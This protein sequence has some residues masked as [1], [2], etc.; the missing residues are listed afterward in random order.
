MLPRRTL[1]RSGLALGALSGLAGCGVAARA[2]REG[3][4][5]MA[6]PGP[7]DLDWAKTAWQ[8]F[9]TARNSATGLVEA[10]AGAGFAMTSTVGD[11]I[12]AAVCAYRLGAIDQREFD[13]T[14]SQLLQF[15]AGMALSGGE[16]PARFYDTSSGQ[17]IDPPEEGRDPGWSAVD[18]GR[19]LVWLRILGSEFRQYSPFVAKIVERWDLCIALD[20]NG[21]MLRK[22]PGEG[23]MVTGIDLGSGS[24]V[25]GAQGLRAWGLDVTPL[26][27]STGEFSL[28]VEG[29]EFAIG[30]DADPLPPLLTAPYALLGIEFGWSKPAGG[31]LAQE[32]GQAERLF[33]VQQRRSVR[34]G[35]ATAR[36]D[37]RRTSEPYAVVDT[38]LAG[39]TPWNTLAPGGGSRPDLALIS[40][41]A[42]FAIWALGSPGAGG[43]MESVRTLRDAGT[44]WFEGR[45]EASGGYEWTRTASTNAMVLEALLYR[46]VGTLFPSGGEQPLVPGGSAGVACHGE[47]II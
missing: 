5:G 19:L 31:A 9:R 47:D 36:S 35:I 22:L 11:Q 6:S 25:Y 34:T 33:T 45:Y 3:L 20:P 43:A 40:T 4:T 39:G 29:M 38:V 17:V 14:V 42:A 1:L 46:E 27:L 18:L 16:L 32:R 26:P 37:F 13:V 15:L 28:T 2:I 44:G 12:A 23:G 24:E 8:Y 7:R 30:T 10:I 41:K 21:R